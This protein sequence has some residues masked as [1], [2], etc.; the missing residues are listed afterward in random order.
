MAL[1]ASPAEAA[2]GGLSGGATDASASVSISYTYDAL[3][4]VTA[5]IYSTGAEFHYDYD[6]V[7][8]V[9]TRTQAVAGMAVVT[10][11]IYNAANQLVTAHESNSATIWYYAYDATGRLT[12]ITPDGTTPAKGARRYTYNS[13]GYLIKAEI[14]DGSA[15]QPQAAMTYNGLGQRVQMTGWASGLSATTTYVLDLTSANGEPLEADAQGKSTFYL[16]AQGRPLAELTDSWAYYLADGTDTPRQMTD[17]AGNVTLARSYTP[18]GEVMDQNG[19]GDF[20]WGYFGGLMDAATGLM[21][22][23]NGQYYDP[24]TGRFL[25]P[26][27]QRGANPYVPW[28]SNPLGV[29]VGPLGL[30]AFWPRKRKLGKGERVLL[31]VMLIVGMSVGLAAC[32]YPPQPPQPHPEEPGTPPRQPVRQSNKEPTQTKEAPAAERTP[33]PIPTSTSTSTETATAERPKTQ[34]PATPTGTSTQT[35]TPADDRSL[36]QDGAKIKRLYDTMKA[37]TSGWWYANG[38]FTVKEFSG[39]LTMHEAAGIEFYMSPLDVIVAA[40]Q[41][42]VGGWNPSYCSSI[43]VCYNGAFNF[44]GAFSES[45]NKLVLCQGS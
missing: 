10:S 2:T 8:N 28:Q 35:E 42:F 30:L 33:A 12:D 23:G 13:V 34:C 22:V 20:T 11:Y 4:R 21:Y 32:N 36:T 25:A 38:D 1:G 17:A 3:Y 27:N 40:Q 24:A 26:V 6:A 29:I 5:A 45:A 37:A 39:L 18:W 15:Y 14:H 16:Y 41:L 44:W 19:S 9:L 7:G 43:S 31:M